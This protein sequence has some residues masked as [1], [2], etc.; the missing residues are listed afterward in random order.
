MIGRREE[1]AMNPTDRRMFLKESGALVV[2]AVAATAAPL[3]CRSTAKPDYPKD[4]TGP[5]AIVSGPSQAEGI[6]RF[7]SRARYEDLTSDRRERLK[8]SVLDSLA[9][10]INALGAPLLEAS[11]AQVDEFSGPGGR[12]TLIGGGRSN[13]IDAAFY[14]TAL[15]RYVDFMDSYLAGGGLCHPSNN[16]AAILA[17]RAN[18]A[19]VIGRKRSR[20]ADRNT[21]AYHACE[22]GRWRVIRKEALRA[23]T[24][25]LRF[26][27]VSA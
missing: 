13:P 6:A 8:V 4:A 10:A 19:L 2:S 20:Q 12:C 15:V 11:R 26:S 22:P 25:R 9:C 16:M 27:R 18:P 23:R 17:S 24:R 5:G 14:N 7:G 21:L 3:A 1:K